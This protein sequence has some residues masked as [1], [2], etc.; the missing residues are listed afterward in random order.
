M[1]FCLHVAC[2]IRK[3]QISQDAKPR[4]GAGCE[5]KQVH[6]PFL[7]NCII[8][9]LGMTLWKLYRYVWF[10]FGIIHVS[11]IDF[12]AQVTGHC[13]NIEH[14]AFVIFVHLISAIEMSLTLAYR[15][16]GGVVSSLNHSFY[17]FFIH[18]V[19]D[20]VFPPVR[21]TNDKICSKLPMCTVSDI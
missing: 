20:A 16:I 7:A 11:Q 12:E 5:P 10:V 13:I 17:K 4:M 14:I 9:H 1:L 2:Q 18:V 15:N 8:E 19:Q 6:R 21:V 3:F